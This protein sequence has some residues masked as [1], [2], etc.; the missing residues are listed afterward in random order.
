MTD[1]KPFYE[2]R[3]KKVVAALNKNLFE[4]LYAP[5]REQAVEEILK[6]IPAGATVGAGGS[7]TLREINILEILKKRGHTVYDHWQQG[8]D[9]AEVD[10]IRRRQLTSD[11]FLSSSN[12]VTS[13]GHLVNIDGAGNRV[14]SMVFGPKKVIVVVGINKIVRDREAAIVRIK[15]EAA[16]KN[17]YRMNLPTPCAKTTFC[18]DCSPPARFCRVTAV[19]EVKPGGIPEFVVIIVGE[20]LGF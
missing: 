2:E 6:R 13:E 19:T 4:A 11:V 3:A 18:T 16:P 14:A 20:N 10:E 8:L 15:N 5:G 1:L 17:F 7:V 9:P 12:A